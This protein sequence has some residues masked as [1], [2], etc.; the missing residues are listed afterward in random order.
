MTLPGLFG[1]TAISR[2]LLTKLV[3][4]VTNFCTD[5]MFFGEAD[6]NTSALAPAVICAAAAELAS[7]LKTMF[8]PG[9]ATLNCLPIVVNASVSDAAA[10][11]VILPDNAAAADDAAPDDAARTTPPDDHWP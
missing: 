9:C 7:K 10:R 2:E 1:G 6:A 11:T 3:G 5:V 8:V 4:V